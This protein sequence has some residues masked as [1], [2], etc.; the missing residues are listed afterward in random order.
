MPHSP[1]FALAAL[2][3]AA[4]AALPPAAAAQEP[5][6]RRT[7]FV[8]V[9]DKQG[10][11]VKGLRKDRFVIHD[12]KRAQEPESLAERDEP[13]TVGILVDVSGSMPS[14]LTEALRE[15]L[16]DFLAAAHPE[17][18]YFV[19]AFNQRPQ[20]LAEGV[21]G[22]EAVLSAVGR[23]ASAERKGYT[24]LFDALY[25]A[26]Q[27]CTRGRHPKRVI[28][29][30]TDGQDNFSDFTFKELKRALAEGDAIVYALGL[31]AGYGSQDFAGR[32]I[33]EELTGLTGGRA[34]FLD[35]QRALKL[36][37]EYVAA[38]LRNQ[39]VLGF[40]AAPPEK[41]AGWRELKVRLNEVRDERGR[42]IKFYVRTRRGFYDEAAPGGATLPR[43]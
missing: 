17:N 6:P 21:T 16:S 11:F 7:L 28:L 5:A 10:N 42:L 30:I 26:A 13:A 43:R 41:G 22:R 9:T 38:E 19:V 31:G 12:G 8:T 35:D 20:L 33:L 2:L 1:C 29:V 40:A 18:E 32:A 27:R 39:Y 14:R 23:L 3:C 24:A 37:A 4:L 36:A 25:L 34:I 15:A